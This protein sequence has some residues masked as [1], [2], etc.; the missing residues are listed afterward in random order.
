MNKISVIIPVYNVEIYLEKCLQSVINQTLSDIEIICINDG[1]TDNS[2]DILKK[3][4]AIDKRIILIN[5]E[6]QGVATARNIGLQKA[7]TPYIMFVDSD[8]WLELNAAEV[9]YKAITENN[10]DLVQAKTNLHYDILHN[11]KKGDEKFFKSLPTGNYNINQ[12]DFI[13]IS[14]TPW[15]KLWKKE[16][17]DKYNITFPVGLHYEDVAFMCK[18]LAVSKNILGIE[19]KL[20]NYLRR[21]LSIMT[22]TYYK[23]STMSLDHIKVCV[24]FYNYLSTWHLFNKYEITFWVIF[25]EFF[26]RAIKGLH[27]KNKHLAFDLAHAF[28]VDKN[29]E[30]LGDRL[31]SA[32]YRTLINL[33][34]KN[35][36]KIYTIKPSLLAKIFFYQ[37]YNRLSKKIKLFGITVYKQKF[38]QSGSKKK[39]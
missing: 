17:I 35:Y 7:T 36:A 13:N 14:H 5:Q 19:N 4:E 38:N 8:D 9:M 26:W 32:V 21:P 28:I 37:K 27:T 1:S 2:S 18:Y 10:C 30:Q 3:Y 20:Y 16:I 31:D 34:N 15:G 23:S 24:D 25:E 29:I 11:L 33:K 12:H 6:N 22:K 39:P